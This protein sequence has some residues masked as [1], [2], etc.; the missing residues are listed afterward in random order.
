MVCVGKAIACGAV[1]IVNAIACGYGAALG[2]DLWTKASVKLTNEKNVIEGKIISDPAENPVLIKKTIHRVLSYFNLEDE[3]GAR[4]ET[5]SNIPIAR[6]LKSSS[7]AANALVLATLS[8]LKK[9]IDDLEVVNLGVDAALDSNVTITGAFDDACASYF[10]NIIITDNSS[11]K[12]MKEFIPKEKYTILIYTPPR[13][14]YTMNSNVD[15]MQVISREIRHIHRE[16]L[17]GN[18][19]TA[20]TLNG[21]AYS[22]LLGYDVSIAIEAL[23][24]GAIAASLSGTGPAV[25]AVVDSEYEENVKSNWQHREG[26]V[27]ETQINHQK[28]RI[29]M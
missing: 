19:W 24:A 28:A 13:K 6:G 21:L 9:N 29:L 12:I 2:I 16:A 15:K 18:Y 10:G 27:I 26:K 4:V 1:T 7:T 17:S 5:S 22:S 25:A 3:Y 8:A 11:R 20:M 14:A 23:S